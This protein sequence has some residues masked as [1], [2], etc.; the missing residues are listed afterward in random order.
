MKVGDRVTVRIV[1]VR[2]DPPPVRVHGT[3]EKIDGDNVVVELDS[4]ITYITGLDK[5]EAEA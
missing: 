3:I 4:G 2:A 1:W 5:L